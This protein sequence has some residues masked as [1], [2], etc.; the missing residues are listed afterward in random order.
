MLL[1]MVCICSRVKSKIYGQFLSRIP[2][3][4]GSSKRCRFVIE[5]MNFWS[6][7]CWINFVS[8]TY[9][10]L[11]ILFHTHTHTFGPGLTV[12]FWFFALQLNETIGHHSQR[13][14]ASS[15]VFIK[16]LLWIFP[17]NSK[18]LSNNYTMLGCVSILVV[19][20][21]FWSYELHLWSDCL[22]AVHS[23][24]M[25]L[26]ILGGLALLFR[27][28]DFDTF[29]LGIL[30]MLLFTPVSFLCW[31]RPAYKAFR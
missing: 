15:R 23:C 14:A 27:A 28:G 22:F 4:N 5:S 17:T 9:F 25:V 19:Y 18:K 29:G 16:I 21:H 13:N 2:A 7:R 1:T 11:G 30:Y 8:T 24:V 10:W 6:N 3:R 26:N 20:W 31:F 12:L